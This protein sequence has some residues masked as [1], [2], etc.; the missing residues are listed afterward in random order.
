MINREGRTGL[1]EHG[2]GWGRGSESDTSAASSGWSITSNKQPQRRLAAALPGRTSLHRIWTPDR[3]MAMA[4]PPRRAAPLWCAIA[5]RQTS[6]TATATQSYHTHSRSIDPTNRRRASGQNASRSQV[7]SRIA[8]RPVQ[9]RSNP[10]LSSRTQTQPSNPCRW[11][12]PCG[13]LREPTRRYALATGMGRGGEDD[14]TS[15]DTAPAPARTSMTRCGWKKKWADL[16]SF[17]S[18]L[19]P[20]AQF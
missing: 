1:H 12:C 6:N 16:A 20:V 17:R 4:R 8:A 3:F 18:V 14:R 5:G 15:D 2:G 11:V 13:G 7:W 19:S 9:S 10:P